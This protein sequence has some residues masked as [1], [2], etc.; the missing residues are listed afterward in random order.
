VQPHIDGFAPVQSRQFT[1]ALTLPLWFGLGATTDRQ[2]NWEIRHV[3]YGQYEVVVGFDSAS[4]PSKLVISEAI[5]PIQVK[6]PDVEVPVVRFV[7]SL[8][9]LAPIDSNLTTLTPTLTWEPYPSAAYYTVTVMAMPE[10]ATAKAS[11]SA[12]YT[13]WTQSHIRSTRVTM[14]SQFFVVAP[15]QTPEGRLGHLAPGG[16]YMWIVFAHDAS[17]RII[18]SSEHYRLDKEPVFVTGSQRLEGG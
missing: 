13:C 11:E 1:G 6:R 15:R 5:A 14:S 18:S 12:N 3:P 17:G 9:P 8:R 10:W 16:T 7:R 2:G 4:L